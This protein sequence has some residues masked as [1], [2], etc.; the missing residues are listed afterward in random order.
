MLSAMCILVLLGF[1]A[2]A[3]DIG[4][5]LRAKRNPQSAADAGAINARG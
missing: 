5:L 2:L 1:M 3:V 4:L